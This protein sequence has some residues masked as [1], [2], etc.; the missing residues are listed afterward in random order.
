LLLSALCPAAAA[1]QEQ[2][3]YPSPDSG[4]V[5]TSTDVTYATDDTLALKMD[6]YRPTG[7]GPVRPTLIFFN[8]AVGPQRA[9]FFYRRWAE[10][11][12]SRGLV[13]I[14]PDLRR[15]HAA[16]DFQRLLRHLSAHAQEYGVD[17]EAIAVYAASG[18]A[19]TALPLLL[20]TALTRVRSAVIYYGAAEVAEFRPDL[21]IL[22][23][24]AGLDRPALN[25]M[26]DGLM[27]NA[28]PQNAPVTLLNHPSG[29]HAFEMRNDDALTRAVIEETIQFVK[30]TTDSAYQAALRRGIPEALAARHVNGGNFVDAVPLYAEL[31]RVRPEDA[32]L[33]L[34]YGEALLGNEQYA[35]ACAQLEQLVGKGLGPRDLGLPAARAC[36][37]AGDA[38]A[39]LIWLQR[40]PKQF[41]PPAVATEETFAPLRNRPEFRALFEG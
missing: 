33:R 38:D 11:A 36:M 29:Y 5:A 34:A 30:R 37:L 26:I 22:F 1:A 6:V 16:A 23:V 17:S 19:F 10:T 7:G 27:A 20:D 8:Q 9:F 18:N 13:G 28:W 3:F 12:A 35:E 2:F 32:T 14:V 21:P 4:S 39:A 15:E 40:I 41:I 24:R 31:V 25:T